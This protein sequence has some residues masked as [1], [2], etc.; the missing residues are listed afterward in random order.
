[1]KDW[2]IPS[3][4]PANLAGIEPVRDQLVIL[5]LYTLVGAGSLAILGSLSRAWQSG[6]QP[7]MWVHTGSFLALILLAVF[8]KR[9]PAGIPRLLLL[10]SL[11]M[12]GL[13]GL[14]IYG[15]LSLGSV[16]FVL[17]S[18]LC[19]ALYG[20][21]AGLAATAVTTCSMA[22]VA[23]LALRGE[24]VFIP[25]PTAYLYSETAWLNA[26]TGTFAVTIIAVFTTNFL[27]RSLL[28]R[29]ASQRQ[30]IE[31]LQSILNNSPDIV[32]LLDKLGHIV[33]ISRMEPGYHTT[34][35]VI[36]R[37][38]AE[39]A[40]PEDR[41]PVQAAID[42]VVKTRAKRRLEASYLDLAGNAHPYDIHFA[43][44]LH[45]G[46]VAG[47]SV[48]ARDIDRERAA[49]LA[50][51]KEQAFNTAILE[52]IGALVVVLDSQGRIILFNQ[53]CEQTTGYRREDV[54]G[55]A[56]WDFLLA[57]E[58][59]APVMDVF[60][61]L[62]AGHFPNTHENDWLARDG[63]R[64]RI[65]WSN[66]VLTEPGG[67]VTHVVATGLDVTRQAETE[68]ALARSEERMRLSQRYAEIG[69]WEWD[70]P[71]GVVYWSD[72]IGP[73]FG[74]H[75]SVPETTYE[76]F[77]NAIHPDDRPRVVEAVNA[78]VHDDARYDI[79]HRVLWPDGTV[80][81]LRERGGMLRSDDGKPLRMLGVVQDVTDHHQ[82]LVALTES[83]ELFREVA[84]HMKTVLWVRDL[85]S[86]RMIYVNPAY[87]ALWHRPA[88]A[89]LDNP[90]DFLE[91]VHPDDLAE[92]RAA[93]QQQEEGEYFNRRYRVIRDDGEVRW[94]LA[95]VF[96]IRDEQ[97]T[98]YRLG[99][100][101]QDV[102]RQREAEEAQLARERRQ[103]LALVQEVHHRIKNHLQGIAGLL[104]QHAEQSPETATVLNGAI[105]QI[106]SIALAH[107]L[108][109]QGAGSELHLCELVP[110]IVKSITH[111]MNAQDR[112]ELTIDMDWSLKLSDADTVP[113]ALI[114]NELI[115][116]CL[117]H[118][119]AGVHRPT[120]LLL[121]ERHGEARLVMICPE[122]RLPV[123]FDFEQNIGL[124]TGLELV[125][126]LLP[127]EGVNL[128]LEN[129]PEGVNCNLVLNYPVVLR[130]SRRPQNVTKSLVY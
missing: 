36:G 110:A 90:L 94:V 83:Q 6:W 58:E 120:R 108:Q 60:N 95:Q 15:L 124:G 24:L 1:M 116:N 53:A 37:R 86:N 10:G 44:V 20:F 117:K 25:D 31:L 2:R 9:L 103:V 118:R 88:S 73:L 29:Q 77:L 11:Y 13:A 112:I 104:H 59:R 32:I 97:G 99:G 21:G 76:N 39:L 84:E 66:T 101:A 67:R 128:I 41:S 100:F 119:P 71:S 8:A 92:V 38:M 46:E 106:R 78:C 115:V 50:L 81:W 12:T 19:V 68:A 45:D 105:A 42:E 61:Q 126:A 54:L 52:T 107:G 65:A 127:Q 51:H 34:A 18:I 125:K 40:I 23:L 80:R 72:Q 123:A 14:F 111:S 85:R 3:P 75:G 114:F 87:A 16:V 30:S 33:F 17:V 109:G 130:G 98:V 102:T 22:A 70:I 62:T 56:V 89:L 79:E 7:V 55:K 69:T 63:S 82:S 93:M 57:P 121:S 91:C 122:A 47:L 43:P 4:D 28:S 5:L 49:E 64:R 26:V 129:S 113:M 74:H 96:P 48:V 27:L 35:Q